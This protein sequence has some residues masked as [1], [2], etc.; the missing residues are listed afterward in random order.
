VTTAKTDRQVCDVTELLLTNRSLMTVAN[1]SRWL[2]PRSAPEGLSLLRAGRT[3]DDTRCQHRVGADRLALPDVPDR[4]EV[5][6]RF[7][8]RLSPDD[9]EAIT[10][11][12]FHV[13]FGGGLDHRV[14]LPLSHMHDRPY[15]DLGEMS[16]RCGVGTEISASA[17]RYG[18]SVLGLDG[19]V[20]ASAAFPQTIRIGF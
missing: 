3:Y 9:V 10:P 17:S 5:I 7:L 1:S 19:V 13:G 20:P 18:R 2:G 11:V 16:A 6:Y 15:A 8:D 14:S 12:R 4:R